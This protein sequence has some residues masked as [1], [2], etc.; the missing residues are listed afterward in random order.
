MCWRKVLSAYSWYAALD[1]FAKHL[2]YCESYHRYAIAYDHVV[3][4]VTVSCLKRWTWND[5]FGGEKWQRKWRSW[6]WCCFSECVSSSRVRSETLATKQGNGKSK[7]HTKFQDIPETCFRIQ[8][9]PET[10]G[11]RIFLKQDSGYYLV[12]GILKQVS[13]WIDI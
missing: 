2:I 9:I 12:S 5:E 11:F 13:I 7:R 3:D 6:N 8:D 1:S 10:S 4:I